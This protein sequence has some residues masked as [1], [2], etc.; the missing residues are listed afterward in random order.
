M[1]EATATAKCLECVKYKP[2]EVI[3]I[4][5]DAPA[6]LSIV[7]KGSV[8]IFL[9]HRHGSAGSRGGS[10]G[11]GTEGEN[12]ADATPRADTGAPSDDQHP[13]RR[14]FVSYQKAL[15][16]FGRCDAEFAP[17]SPPPPPLDEPPPPT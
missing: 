3:F 10:S 5:G 14:T 8:D 4:Q 2:G 6:Y 1:K 11:A 13:I 15:K 17:F 12:S 16:L 9:K 7:V